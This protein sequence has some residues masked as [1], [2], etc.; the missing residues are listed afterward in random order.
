MQF[1]TIALIDALGFKGIWNDRRGGASNA[2]ATLR[3]VKSVLDAERAWAAEHWRSITEHESVPQFAKAIRFTCHFMSD[4]AAIAATVPLPG[5]GEDFPGKRA[6]A[7]LVLN[8]TVYVICRAL[9]PAIRAAALAPTPIAY[10]GAIACGEMEIDDEFT[11]GPAVDD[12]ASGMEAADGAFVWF[13]PSALKFCRQMEPH[14]WYTVW[15]R[16]TEFD[17]PLKG[18]TFRTRV[19]NPLVVQAETYGTIE[20]EPFETALLSSFTSDDVKIAVKR[21]NTARF[22][23]AARHWV[24]PPSFAAS[25]CQVQLV[26]WLRNGG[27]ERAAIEWAASEAQIRRDRLLPIP[28]RFPGTEEEAKSLLRVAEISE[29]SAR[30]FLTGAFTQW[31]DHPPSVP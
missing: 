3:A 23:S 16:T 4:T 14:D 28:P 7:P 5:P 11:I 22:L 20:I 12:A 25:E 31:I 9:A 29:T 10:R 1:G 21:Q 18:R 13:M 17:V 24:A 8:A 19:I 15:E 6:W 27:I 2:R 26:G 30:D